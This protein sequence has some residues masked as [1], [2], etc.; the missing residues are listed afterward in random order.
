VNDST[1]G[2]AQIVFSTGQLAEFI[3]V[4]SDSAVQGSDVTNL[5]QTAANKIDAALGS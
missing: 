2:E 4:G 1:G 3:F 5:A